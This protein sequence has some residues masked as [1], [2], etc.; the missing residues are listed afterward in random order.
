MKAWAVTPDN[1][2]IPLISIPDWDFHWQGMYEFRHP[3]Y[4]PTGT[5][6]HGEA[7]YDNTT[8]NDA[9]PNDPPAWVALGEA[10]TD[11]MML[12]YFAY[13]LGFPSDTL[14]VVDDSQHSEHHEN[15]TTDFNIGLGETT[16][17]ENVRIAP[18]PAADRLSVTV[19]GQGSSF[20]LVDTQGRVTA[21]QHLNAGTNTV[22]VA[23]LAR[24]TLIAE[25][26]GAGG[27]VLYRNPILL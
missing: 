11:E 22:D 19:G 9:N 21:S 15:C 20:R 24:G 18:V 1:D 4:L 13:T 10:T 26:R 6:L 8:G 3:I 27:A 23:T 17:S 7:T 2:T 14:V 12:F 5:V 16:V 25:V